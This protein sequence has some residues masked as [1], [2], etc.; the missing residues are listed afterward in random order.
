M[1]HGKN[2]RFLSFS[3]NNLSLLFTLFGSLES[4][5]ELLM[6]L[7]QESVVDEEYTFRIKLCNITSTLQNRK[8]REAY[9][10][11]KLTSMT[12]THEDS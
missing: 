2:S 6:R 7:I 10:L 12:G 9:T 1:N 8:D 11:N 5:F 4:Q 3:F